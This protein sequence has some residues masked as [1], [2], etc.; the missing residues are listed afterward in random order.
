MH[1]TLILPTTPCSTKQFLSRR[2]PHQNR[3]SIHSPP[4]VPSHTAPL[5][6]R[7]H[8]VR[9]AH[10]AASQ[11]AIISSLLPLPSILNIFFNTLFS[12]ILSLPSSINASDDVSIPC[13][14]ARQ[15]YSSVCCSVY[16]SI[17]QTGRQKIWA[18]W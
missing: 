2:F 6:G 3:A 12:N 16:I 17:R 7:Y 9:T 4:Y 8:I 13:T 1:F 10:H 15:H 5:D 14:T 11:Y 18:E